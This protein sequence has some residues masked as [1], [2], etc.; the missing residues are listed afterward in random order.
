[1]EKGNLRRNKA[2]KRIEDLPQ[3]RTLPQE[4]K[5]E[6]KRRKVQGLQTLGLRRSTMLSTLQQAVSKAME[7]IDL[8]ENEPTKNESIENEPIENPKISLRGSSKSSPRLSPLP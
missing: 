3:T 4:E 8:E 6:T 5:S 7:Y 2:S 1:M